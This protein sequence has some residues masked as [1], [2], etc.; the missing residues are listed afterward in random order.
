MMNKL[1]LNLLHPNKRF[2]L[3]NTE[4]LAVCIFYSTKPAVKR[5]QNEEIPEKI[6]QTERI[7][8]L[9]RKPH[10][11]KPQK[12]PFAKNLFVGNFDPDILTYPQ[13]EKD[14][15]ENLENSL[16][17]VADF[18][19]SKEAG[20][21]KNFSDKFVDKLKSLYLFGLRAPVTAGGRE[22]THTEYCK[23][24]EII[25]GHELG[26]SLRYS[27][28]F[29]IQALLKNGSDELKA[30]YL[31]RLI[32]GELLSAFC[33]HEENNNDDKDVRTRAERNPDGSWVGRIYSNQSCR[34]LVRIF[35]SVFFIFRRSMAKKLGL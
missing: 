24:G 12:P 25:A 7:T 15:L 28:Q 31:P 30:K 23:F 6:K 18:F 27:E 33:I 14:E 10:V 1:S 29:G 17:P 26:C 3:N 9:F 20:E 35:D 4:R 34:F 11:K 22:L 8:H 13:L 21:T 5:D 2:L 19:K 16:K 32:S